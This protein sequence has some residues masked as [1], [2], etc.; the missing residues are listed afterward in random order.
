MNDDSRMRRAEAHVTY[1]L[2]V[3]ALIS[4]AVLMLSY[5]FGF[6]E[7]IAPVTIILV[8][9]VF[10]TY[11]IYPAVHWLRSRGL[12]KGGAIAFVYVSA[13][14][15]FGFALSFIVPPF[16]K[17]TKDLTGSMP[18]FVRSAS[19]Y[20]ANPDSPGLRYLPLQLRDYLATVPVQLGDYV[21]TQAAAIS[22]SILS[23]LLSAFGIIATL[24]VIPIL[25]IYLIFEAEGLTAAAVGLM[26]LGGRPETLRVL[27][28][29]DKVLGGF[30]RGQVIVGATIGI[31]ITIGLT[32]VHVPYALVIGIAAGVLD[33]IPYI[34]AVATFIPA[35]MLGFQSGGWQHAV[36]VA[37]IFV[38][39]FQAEGHFIS[40]R[41][42]SE[43]VGLSPLVVIVAVLV[44]GELLGIPGM[45]IAVPIAGM[46]RVLR[47]HFVPTHA[48]AHVPEPAAVRG[49]T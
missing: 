5:T 40:P 6:L 19:A 45:F 11:L 16:L 17:E 9:T 44:G 8:G 15:L 48:P 14:V 30:I 38:A 27:A 29:L 21:Q 42:V 2:K 4:L 34:G 23:I 37:L 22:T 39:V 35:V 25:S 18:A 3:L 47:Q 24:V 20:I 43:S 32:I 7:R 36:I 12:S 46:L 1:W 41:I 26:P 10:F 33:I 49:D 31:C 13:L 28:D